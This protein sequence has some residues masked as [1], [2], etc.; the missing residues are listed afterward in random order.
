LFLFCFVCCASGCRNGVNLTLV[1]GK[2]NAFTHDL[3]SP[4]FRQ[5][6]VLKVCKPSSRGKGK[7]EEEKEKKKNGGGGG[8]G[9]DNDERWSAPFR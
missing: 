7:E 5:R 4:R 8:G 1:S 3:Y 9:G 2:P 6:P